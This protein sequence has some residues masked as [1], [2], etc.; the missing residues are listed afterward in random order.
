M[1]TCTESGGGGEKRYKENIL[2]SPS[3]SLSILNK[4]RTF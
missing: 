1:K 4:N 3:I 2:Y